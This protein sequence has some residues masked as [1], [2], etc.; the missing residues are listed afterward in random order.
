MLTSELGDN[1]YKGAREEKYLEAL[2]RINPHIDV[3]KRRKFKLQ[4][5]KAL[6]QS[7][8]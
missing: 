3:E 7:E 8:I 2:K 5:A 4:T 6:H 1:L